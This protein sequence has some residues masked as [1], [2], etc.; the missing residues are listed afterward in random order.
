MA[1]TIYFYN[2]GIYLNDKL[3]DISFLDFIDKIDSIQKN[4]LQVVRKVDDKISAIFS[5]VSQSEQDV[6]VVPI[7]K[8]R[9]DFKPYVGELTKSDLNYI[10]KEVIELVTLYYN[11]LY[12]VAALTYNAN[13]LKPKDIENYLNTFLPQNNNQIWKVKL[14]PIIINK[15]IE[16]IKN[17]EQGKKI[18]LELNLDSSTKN[19]IRENAGINEKMNIFKALSTSVE[20]EFNANTLKLEFGIG[21]KKTATME[22]NA[23]LHLLNLLEIDIDYISSVEITYKDNSTDKVDTLDLKNKSSILKDKI[24]SNSSDKNPAQQ[25]ISGEI[26]KIAEKHSLNIT[27]AYRNYWTNFMNASFPELV[28]EPKPENVVSKQI[29]INVNESVL[30][31]KIS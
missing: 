21:N 13:G 5:L 3:S 17:S 26:K 18:A 9:L 19:F 14:E 16:K 28:L 12:K 25:I 15:G 20:E 22:L 24:L 31:E 1:R 2:I 6:R 4:R 30:N 10:D 11:D 8:F 29:N 7:G 23:V 27:R